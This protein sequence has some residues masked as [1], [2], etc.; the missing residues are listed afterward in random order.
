LRHN[1][2]FYCQRAVGFC[3]DVGY[4]DEGYFNALVRMFEQALTVTDQL[5]VSQRSSLIARL[6]RT[7]AVG[8]NLGYGVG[9]DVDSLLA[10]YVST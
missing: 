2:V 9:D 8:H 7:R 10:K 4:Q 1:L 3:S 6:D 5:S